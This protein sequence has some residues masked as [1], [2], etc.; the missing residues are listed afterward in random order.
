LMIIVAVIFLI[1][2]E[3]IFSETQSKLVEVAK[4]GMDSR[5]S[6]INDKC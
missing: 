5:S 4:K 1:A 3:T 2:L 6:L